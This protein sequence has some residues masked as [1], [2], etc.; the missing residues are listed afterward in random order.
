M[1]LV[2]KSIFGDKTLQGAD[3]ICVSEYDAYYTD[4]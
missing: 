1:K 3:G 4:V 2:L